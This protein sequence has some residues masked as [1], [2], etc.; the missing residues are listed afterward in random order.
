[1]AKSHDAKDASAFGIHRPRKLEEFLDY[2]VV[3]T[4]FT[5]ESFD[6]KPYVRLHL[7]IESTG[8]I[9]ELNSGNKYVLQ[10]IQ[11]VGDA[12]Q[13]P[14]NVVFFKPGERGKAIAV[15]GWEDE[16]T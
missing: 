9:V 10:F 1:M 8:E 6:G 16:N 3:L 11:A 12:T 5:M 7:L 2:R 15:K 13:C 4:N 14:I